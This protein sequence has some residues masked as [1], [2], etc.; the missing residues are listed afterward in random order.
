MNALREKGQSPGLKRR[1]VSEMTPTLAPTTL[2]SNF[3]AQFRMPSNVLQSE[4]HS[5]AI[6]LANGLNGVSSEGIRTS[7]QRL[8]TPRQATSLFPHDRDNLVILARRK[9]TNL[10]R[11]VP[12]DHIQTLDDF[13]TACGIVWEIE[14]ARLFVYLPGDAKGLVEIVASRASSFTEAMRMFPRGLDNQ[15]AVIRVLV[16]SGGEEL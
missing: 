11:T 15:P 3:R 4:G 16:L 8:A 1:K 13:F 10:F 14:A 12:I 7:S 6:T 2:S 9:A 5:Q